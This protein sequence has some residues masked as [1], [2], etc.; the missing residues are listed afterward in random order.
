M[1]LQVRRSEQILSGEKSIFYFPGEKSD[2]LY[3]FLGFIYLVIYAYLLSYL[4]A[5]LLFFSNTV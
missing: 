2:Y 3:R 1:Y 4:G 5:Y